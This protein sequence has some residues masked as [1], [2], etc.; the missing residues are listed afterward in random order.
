MFDGVVDGLQ[1]SHVVALQTELLSLFVGDLDNG[2][3]SK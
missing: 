3:V 1:F 2:R